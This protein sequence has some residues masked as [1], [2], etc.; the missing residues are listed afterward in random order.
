MKKSFLTI[1]LTAVLVTGLFTHCEKKLDLAPLGAL[2]E[3]TYYQT[4]DDFKGAAVLAYSTLLNYTYEQFDAGGW[5]KGTGMIDDDQTSHNNGADNIEEFNWRSTDGTWSALWATTYKGIQRANIIIEKLP[6]AKAVPDSSKKVF[7][8]EARFLRGY[9]NFFLAINWGNPPLITETARTLEQTRAGNSQPGE[10]WDAAI[11]DL[12]LAKAGLPAKWDD[13]NRGRATSGAASAMLGKLL[14]FRAQWEKKPALYTEAAAEFQGLIGKYTLVKNYQDNFTTLTE[15]NAE[16]VFEIQMGLGGVNPWLPADLGFS[17]GS[18]A[19]TARLIYYRAACGP[20][21]NCAPGSGGTGY[22][23]IEITPGLQKEFE[24]G[25]PRRQMSIFLDGDAYDTG[26][27]IDGSQKWTYSKLWTITGS[28]PAKY[29]SKDVNIDY[30]S[31]LSV[32]NLRTI[33]YADVL[34]MLAECKLLGSKD[35]AGAALL[36]NEVRRRADPT[37]K[38]LPDVPATSE[39]QVFKALMHERRVE[40]A[41]EDHRYDDIVRWHLA[42]LINIKTDIDFGRAS[43]NANWDVKNLLKPVPQG[44]RDLNPVLVQNAGY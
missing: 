23:Q 18:S 44:E 12:K 32:N 38:V 21:N 34:L 17:N 36:I 10:L 11:A 13:A 7:E 8:A 22:G 37:G 39:A 25:D 31:P 29:V 1:V 43:T 27:N 19:G 16:S 6:V 3:E 30:R 15:N 5:F 24:A 40:L 35:L 28:T 4:T 42:G 9:F 14:L 33:R 2:N 26:T 41:L 20:N